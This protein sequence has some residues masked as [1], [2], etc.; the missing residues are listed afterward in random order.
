[1]AEFKPAKF[2][3]AEIKRKLLTDERKLIPFGVKILDDVFGGILPSDVVLVGARTGAGKTHLVTHIAENANSL[4]KNVY[5]FALEAERLEVELRA[6]F[7]EM[8]R[9]NATLDGDNRVYNLDYKLWRIN[10]SRYGLRGE[11]LRK[12][13]IEALRTR[14]ASF[15]VYYR[16]KSFTIKDFTRA[17][18]DVHQKSDLIITDHIHYFD[19]FSDNENK[20]IGGAIKKM[21]DIAQ[22]T[23]V[24]NILVAHLRK[25][26]QGA[27]A[28]LIPSIHDF[29][30]SSDLS[31]ICTKAIILAPGGM[32]RSPD[33]QIISKT[34][35]HCNKFRIEGN[36]EKYI[37]VARFNV[38]DKEY[39]D[40]Y[41]IYEFKQNNIKYLTKM[42]DHEVNPQ[43]LHWLGS[44][45]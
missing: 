25:E 43:H 32:E 1:M 9:I 28:K 5:M 8:V 17:A 20:E 33:G 24:P 16:D 2:D 21:R 13:A 36:V 11:T 23:D 12:H 42:K 14:G 44:K 26:Q 4:G 19:L 6:T 31:K 35:I 29:H 18:M 30:G 45:A 27:E 3:D 15:N 38:N 22:L 10:S 37:F 41:S 34:L 39:D 7:K 40:D